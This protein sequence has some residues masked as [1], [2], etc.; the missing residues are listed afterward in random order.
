MMSRPGS[1]I[2]GH[3]AGVTEPST[4]EPDAP[5]AAGTLPGCP[6]KREIAEQREGD[7]FLGVA[8]EEELVEAAQRMLPRSRV[9]AAGQRGHESGMVTATARRH[10]FGVARHPAAHRVRDGPRGEL[11]R[12]RDA[13]GARHAARGAR[14]A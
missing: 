11:D 13:V 10:D 4:R 1:E 8:G 12:R 5:V 2:A 3:Q 9:E 7:R 14:A 6:C